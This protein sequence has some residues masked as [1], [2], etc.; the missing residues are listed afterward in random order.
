MATESSIEI[1]QHIGKGET[2]GSCEAKKRWITYTL[3][4][5]VFLL[6]GHST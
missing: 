6:F 1:P 2:T 3:D 4:Q 5:I